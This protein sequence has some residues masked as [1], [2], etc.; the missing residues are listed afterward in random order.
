MTKS[1]IHLHNFPSTL[2]RQVHTRWK[3]FVIGDYIHPPL[4]GLRQFQS[5]LKVAYIG[6]METEEGRSLRFTI[7]CTPQT[8]DTFRLADSAADPWAFVTDRPFTVQ[9]IRRLCVTTS[10]DT[11]AIWVQFPPEPKD[12][13]L[14]HGLLDLGSSWSNA[15]R[16][17]S[18]HHAPL[19]EAVLV[20][21]EGP[22]YLSVYQGN[23]VI[24]SLKAG[25]YWSVFPLNLKIY[26]VYT[27]F[28][29]KAMTFCQNRY[30]RLS[31]KSQNS[32]MSLNGWL[33]L[34]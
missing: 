11:S 25:K 30:L 14:I 3:S 28:F 6:S 2:A 33:M 1:K 10:V 17:F 7:C 8:D 19:P 15:R 4:P 20:R 12:T 26:L 24:A 9:E 21:A 29:E 31:M 34:I 32:G 5:L 23:F 18:Y 16:A 22:G 13:L 27:R